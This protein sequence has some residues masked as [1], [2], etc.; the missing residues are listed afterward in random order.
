MTDGR[1]LTC[2]EADALA[3]AWG[4]DVL[5]ADEAAAVAEHLETCQQPHAELRASAGAGAV[6]AAALEPIQPSP[7]LRDRVMRSI[8]AAPADGQ[9]I[10]LDARR[11]R[12]SWL[13]RAIAGLAVAAAL[14]LAVWNLG[15][16]GELDERD[17]QLRE[18]AA[19][20]SAGGQA[21]SVSGSIGGGVLVTGDDGPVFVA[22][23]EPPGQDLL[24]ALWLIGPDDVPVPVGTFTPETGEAFAIVPL[25][26]SLE[27][28]ATFAVTRERGRVDAPTGDPVLATAL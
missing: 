6:L 2:D 9:V 1:A 14:V 23:L 22:D 24:Y 18:V 7:G 17:A 21:Y 28:F 3:G 25:D 13:P 12:P 10:Q 8:A 15:L 5:E 20:L 26:R 11:E 4:L 16:R 19:A 27:G